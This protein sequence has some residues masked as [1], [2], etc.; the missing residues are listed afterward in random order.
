[1]AISWDDFD[2]IWASTSPLTPYSFSDNNYKQGWNFVGATP[3]ARQMWDSIQKANDEKFKFLRDN[4]GTPN[5]V[6]TASQMTDTSKVYVYMGSEAGWSNGHWYYYNG[7]AW[8]DGGVY[9]SVAFVTDSTLTLQGQPADA[10]AVGDALALKADLAGCTFTGDV[11]FSAGLST[12]GETTFATATITELT[13]PNA[14]LSNVDARNI[15]S[16]NIYSNTPLTN[17]KSTKVATTQ[18][19]YNVLGDTKTGISTL[20][21]D[22]ENIQALLKGEMY[23][24]QKDESSAVV[25]AVPNNVLPYAGVESVGGKTIVWNQIATFTPITYSKN[26]VTVTITADGEYTFTGTPSVDTDFARAMTD[27]YVVGHKYWFRGCPRTA[28]AGTVYVQIAGTGYVYDYDGIV[29]EAR[30]NTS[31]FPRVWIKANVV[32]DNYTFNMQLFDLTQMFGV[33]NEPTLAE[34]NEMFPAEY[35]E[36]NAGE[37]LTLAPQYI[38]TVGRNLLATNANSGSRFGITWLLQDDGS[39]LVNGKATSGVRI[40]YPAFNLWAWD[41]TTPCWLSGCPNGGG[42]NTYS[43]GVI[44]EDAERYDTY[45]YSNSDYGNGVAFGSGG[46][47]SLANRRDL[48]YAISIHEGCVCDNL[49][50]RPQL[51]YGTSATAFSPHFRERFYIPNSVSALDGYGVSVGSAHNIVDVEMK[52][53]I[54]RVAS[55]DLGTL[56]WSYAEDDDIRYYYT[57]DLNTLVLPRSG[58]SN[59]AMLEYAS[60]TWANVTSGT[61]D[62]SISVDSTGRFALYDSEIQDLT[63]S[64]FQENFSGTILHYEVKTPAVVDLSSYFGDDNLIHVESGGTLTF[65]N[66]SPDEYSIDTP[67]TIEYMIDLNA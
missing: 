20:R 46:H 34:C 17:D 4:F 63:E 56:N 36:A 35:Y 18:F 26:D 64:Q 54:K 25:K 44:G 10:K 67:S 23:S 5:I 19:V 9:N 22:V 11:T 37:F 2:K 42:A 57:D 33:G 8:A 7:T 65:T 13:S 43:L 66:Q 41:G 62:K 50:F 40:E 3:P 30:A 49:V 21:K 28:S 58:V 48:Q 55:V 38:Q 31:R 16:R 6:T 59:V 27:A 32:S 47:T 61:V 29:F 15:T 51:E 45:A 24:Y 52:R 60:D 1:M 39:L 12:T 53:M 14:S